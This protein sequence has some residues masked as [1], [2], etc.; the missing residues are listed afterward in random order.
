M[1]YHGASDE[2]SWVGVQQLK[3][4]LRQQQGHLVPGGNVFH[5]DD[6]EFR[7]YHRWTLSR[8]A[9]CVFETVCLGPRTNTVPVSSSPGA[10][11]TNPWLMH[12]L[13]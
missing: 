12:Q 10:C 8:Y 11:P 6:H 1:F 7:R 2:V 4:P 13:L 5:V 9:V 3:W